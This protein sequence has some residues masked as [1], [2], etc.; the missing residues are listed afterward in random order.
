MS[1]MNSKR[2]RFDD[3]Q[4]DSV[5]SS[6]RVKSNNFVSLSER[7]RKDI[8][9]EFVEVVNVFTIILLL[10]IVTISTTTYICH[11]K[12][13]S[14]GFNKVETSQRSLISSV[15]DMKSSISR[16]EEQLR[17]FIS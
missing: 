3:D 17:S 8:V 12:L 10:F 1:G 6:V 9:S 4:D 5:R 16:I 2:V 14:Q 7:S 11:I 13:M 15:D